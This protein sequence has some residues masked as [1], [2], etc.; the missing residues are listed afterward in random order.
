MN[1]QIRRKLAKEAPRTPSELNAHFK[2]MQAV[3]ESQ[4]KLIEKYEAI[5]KEL[6]GEKAE[7]QL[8]Q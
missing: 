8:V 3:I 4:R 2:R 1:R 6:R 7:G 5:I